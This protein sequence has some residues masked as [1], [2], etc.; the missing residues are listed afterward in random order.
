MP[1]PDEIDA[2]LQL[3]AKMLRKARAPLIYGLTRL[4]VEAQ[5]LAVELAMCLRGAIDTPKGHLTPAHGTSLQLHGE[6]RTTLGELRQY[7]DVLVFVGCE[8]WEQRPDFV[9]TW[10]F[11][12]TATLP[13]KTIY[14][15]DLQRCRTDEEAAAE[16]NEATLLASTPRFVRGNVRFTGEQFSTQVRELGCRDQQELHE[17]RK[18]LGKE[19]STIDPAWDDLLAAWQAAKYPV[20]VFEPAILAD[21]FWHNGGAYLCEQLE[22]VTLERAKFGRAA[23]W[24]LEDINNTLSNAAGAEY[25]LIAR[26]GYPCAVQF[27]KGN[28]EYLPGVTDAASLLH[29]GVIDTALFLGEQ[30]LYAWKSSGAWLNKKGLLISA[31]WPTHWDPVDPLF[32]VQCRGLES[33]TSGIIVR[34]DGV[35]FGL[36]LSDEVAKTWSLSTEPLDQMPTGEEAEDAELASTEASKT[37]PRMEDILRRLLELVREPAIST[38]GAAR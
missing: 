37:A 26:T 19:K 10:A 25:V 17:L 21:R 33:E 9:E 7:A 32:Y 22:R 13:K 4:T 30:N 8:P 12:G 31:R 38:S 29:S 36:P 20:L 23:A 28:A 27:F 1:E 2:Q 18:K 15:V 24:P 34:E 3:I 35:P 5:E 16:Q 6:A 11:A 14:H